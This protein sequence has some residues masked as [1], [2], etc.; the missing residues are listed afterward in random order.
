M[1]KQKHHLPLSIINLVFLSTDHH[2]AK[3][4]ITEDNLNR[5]TPR[6]TQ[7]LR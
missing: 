7:Q 5:N 1:G 6:K 3:L 4:K 2:P